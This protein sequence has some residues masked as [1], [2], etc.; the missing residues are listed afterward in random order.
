MNTWVWYKWNAPSKGQR[1]F[2]L[3]IL[4][5]LCVLCSV[6]WMHQQWFSICHGHQTC[7]CLWRMREWRL[8]WVIVEVPFSVF[9]IKEIHSIIKE[10]GIWVEK[11][12]AFL[13][14]VFLY[15]PLCWLAL[16]GKWLLMWDILN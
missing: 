7:G 4:T 3:N 13:S 1:W 2:G 11:V 12:A 5:L 10:C 8:M 16:N 15:E 9:L 14:W 6:E